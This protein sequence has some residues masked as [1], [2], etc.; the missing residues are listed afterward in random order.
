MRDS[1]A[2]P[3]AVLGGEFAAETRAQVIPG[4]Q[5]VLYQRNIENLCK[6]EATLDDEIRKSVA[7]LY[8][9]ALQAPEAVSYKGA[10]EYHAEAADIPRD[11][12]G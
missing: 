11:E 12:D 4:T 8:K 1:P 5:F 3:L 10:P 7:E 6:D 9:A 2:N